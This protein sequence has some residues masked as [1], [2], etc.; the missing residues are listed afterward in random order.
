VTMNPECSACGEIT[1]PQDARE[2]V[3][4]YPPNSPETR[5]LFR[6]SAA[7]VRVWECFGCGHIAQAGD[8]RRSQTPAPRPLR[9][10]RT[11]RT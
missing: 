1:R 4:N 5:L 7:D 10:P 9:G 11:R 2:L 6:L 8:P 3:F